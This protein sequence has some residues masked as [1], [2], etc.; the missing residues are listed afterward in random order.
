AARRRL[1]EGV[2]R[3]H[4]AGGGPAGDA[5]RGAGMTV[6]FR[7][8]AATPDGN[9]VEG[10]VQAPSRQSVLDELRRQHLYPVAVDE[11]ATA[12]AARAG[13]RLGRRAAV[14]L[15]T[16]NAV[17]LLGAGSERRSEHPEEGAELRSQVRSALLYP[18]LMAVVAS[19]GVVVLLGF[20]IPRFASILADVGSTLPFSTRLLLGA[21]HL[22]TRGW[23]AWLLLAAAAA[24]LVPAALTRPETRRRWHAARLTWP[25]I[26][27]IE[28]KYST[29]RFARTFGLLLKSGV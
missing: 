17:T 8:R 22:L 23:W 24:Y 25:W 16:R 5:R 6:R 13:R 11:A 14:A 21:S 18:A 28:L 4:H 26:G 19:V 10:L 29:A 3:G 7:Y 15:W 1:G 2:R 12:D 9:V 20:V 27:D